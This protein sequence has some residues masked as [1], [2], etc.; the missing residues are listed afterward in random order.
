MKSGRVSSRVVVGR[1]EMADRLLQAIRSLPLEN[2]DTFLADQRNI[3]AAESYLRRGLEA[4][5]DIGRHILAKG[6]GV[7]VSEYKEIGPA[8]QQQGVLVEDEARTLR[9]L[10]GYRNRLVHFYYEVTAEELYGICA[11][12][13]GDVERIADAYR[14]WLKQHPKKLEQG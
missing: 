11:H 2:R 5:L 6:F 3:G 7:A 10:A 8:L 1:L 12:E 4:L 14:R 9:T 13:L